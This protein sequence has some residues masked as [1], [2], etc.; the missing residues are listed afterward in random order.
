MMA[1]GKKRPVC[2]HLVRQGGWLKDVAGKKQNLA[3]CL[4]RDSR[5]GCYFCIAIGEY[6]F[7]GGIFNLWYSRHDQRNWF[8]LLSQH[9]I[10]GGQKDNRGFC[11]TKS[12]NSFFPVT[13]DS[14]APISFVL[15]YRNRNP[16]EVD[17]H[18][19]WWQTQSLHELRKDDRA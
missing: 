3:L 5:W 12:R 13:K 14:Y 19:G 7:P 17:K 9:E 2:H 6:D 11:R 18:D 8:Q 15:S 1:D 4:F 10:N 16:H